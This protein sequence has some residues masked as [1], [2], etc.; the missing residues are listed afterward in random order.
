MGHHRP[1][2]TTDREGMTVLVGDEA[3]SGEPGVEQRW[4]FGKLCPDGSELVDHGCGVEAASD[5]D[6]VTGDDGV[7]MSVRVGSRTVAQGIEVR[8]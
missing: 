6:S 7:T 2:V 4:G 5:K 1:L 8:G 3:V